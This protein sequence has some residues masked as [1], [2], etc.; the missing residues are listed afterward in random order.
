[1]VWHGM[2]WYG[3]VW[4][5]MVWYGMVWEFHFLLFFSSSVAHKLKL[6]C[7]FVLLFAFVIICDK[8]T[9]K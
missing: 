2:V 7:Q 3:M 4:Y 1:M 8:N 5:G 9:L 6:R